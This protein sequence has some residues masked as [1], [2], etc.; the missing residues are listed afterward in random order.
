MLHSYSVI[1]Q[2]LTDFFLNF[3]MRSKFGLVNKMNST[4]QSITARYCL[5]Y[6]HYLH[7]SVWVPHNVIYTKIFFYT[8]HRQ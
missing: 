7:G 6:V 2:N 4:V 1:D 3:D 8:P 5:P